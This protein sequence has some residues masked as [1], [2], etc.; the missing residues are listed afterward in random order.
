MAIIIT[1]EQI[2]FELQKLFGDHFFQ[3]AFYCDNRSQNNIG[4][5]WIKVE[6]DLEGEYRAWQVRDKPSLEEA[7][8]EIIKKIKER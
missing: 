4:K 5:Y 8:V 1:L 3:V 2:E 6:T 7:W